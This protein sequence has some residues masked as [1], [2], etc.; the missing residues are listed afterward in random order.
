MCLVGMPT[1]DLENFDA[2]F[3]E[4]FLRL[5]WVNSMNGLAGVRQPEDQHVAL[6][7][8]PVQRDPDFTE[9]HLG[10]SARGMFLREKNLHAAA[11]LHVDL[12][13]ADPQVVSHG[14]I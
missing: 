13:P 3:Q 5:S 10:L 4:S 14:R 7:L 12:G 2:A 6:R 8:H 11:G 1:Q 9:V